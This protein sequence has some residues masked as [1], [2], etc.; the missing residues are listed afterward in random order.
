[1]LMLCKHSRSSLPS[2]IILPTSSNYETIVHVSSLLLRPSASFIFYLD[3]CDTRLYPI[4]YR[5]RVRWIFVG[6]ISHIDVQKKLSQKLKDSGGSGEYH[7]LRRWPSA[8]MLSPL[9][10]ILST[11]K[12]RS[13]ES[14]SRRESRT[15]KT[16]TCRL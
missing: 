5:L 15:R 9:I 1:M 13:T 16:S 4:H 12:S 2:T 3:L 11:K 8:R 14:F 6:W 10:L 7:Y